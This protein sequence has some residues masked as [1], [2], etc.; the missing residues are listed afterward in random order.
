MK[1]RNRIREVIKYFDSSK[2]ILIQN[3]IL[4]HDHLSAIYLW[5]FRRRISQWLTL[6]QPMLLMYYCQL[7]YH[8]HKRHPSLSALPTHISQYLI[9][10]TI[11]GSHYVNIQNM[12]TLL[13]FLLSHYV[14]TQNMLSYTLLRFLLSIFVLLGNISIRSSIRIWVACMMYNTI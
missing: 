1:V 5:T 4:K 10:Q 14:N 2:I 7:H 9:G 6:Q 3:E 13:R 12:L 11:E 8:S